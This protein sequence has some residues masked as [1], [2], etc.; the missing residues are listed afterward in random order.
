MNPFT[1]SRRGFLGGVLGGAAT[2]AVPLPRAAARRG[3]RDLMSTDRAWERFLADQDLR[4][5]RLPRAWYE[6]PFLGDGFLGSMVYQEPGRNALRFTIH[7]S[8]VQDHRPTFGNEW[9]VARLPVGN[10]ALEPAGE[11]TDVDLRLDLW[12]AELRG[13]LTTSRGRIRLRA[14]IE[15]GRSLL[16]VAIRTTAGENDARLVYRASKAVSPRIIREDPPKAMQPNPDPHTRVEGGV[17]LTVQPLAAGGQTVTAHAEQRERGERIFYLTVAHSHP[18]PTAEAKALGTVRS[19]PRLAV[20]EREHRAWWHRFYRKSFISVPDGLLQSFYWIQLYKLASAARADA[21]IMAT[22][23]PW[24][25]PTPWPSVWNNLNSQLEYWPVY[26]S[27]HL[28]LDPIPRSLKAYQRI[29]VDALRPEFRADSMGLRRST[30]AQFDDAGFV[31]A[32]GYPS[33]DPEIGNLPWLLHNAWLTYRHSMDER[34]LREVVFPILRRAMNYYLHFLKPGDDGRLHLPPTFSPEYGTAPDCNYDLALIRWSCRTLLDAAGRLGVADPLAARWQE[35]LD[36][37]VDPP[38]DGNGFMVGTGVPFAKSHRHYSHMLAVYPLYLVNWDR[39]Q[40]R[41]LIDRS[42]RHWIGFEGA[43]RGYSFTGAS[44][45]SAS[46]GRGDDAL[47]YLRE[48]V[49]RFAQ[50]NTHYYEAGPVIETPLSG[51]QSLHDMLCQSWGGVIRVFPAV[52]AAWR[53]V[54]LHNFL[55]EGAFQVSAVRERGVTRFVRV[56]SLAG[57]TCRLRHGLPGRPA[58]RGTRGRPPAWRDL[59]GGV[60]EIDLARG[61]EAIVHVRG[62]DPDL[63]IA[64]VRITTKAPPWG[65]PPLPPAGQAVPVELAGHFDNDGITSE[66]FMGDGDFDGTGATYPAAA[67]PQTGRVTADG[68]EFLFVNGIEGSANNVTAAGQTIPV[69]AGRYA[70]LHVLGASDNGNTDTTVTAVY[71]DGSSAAVPLRLTDWKSNPAYGESA[72]VRAPQFHTRT[73]AKD[74]AVTIFHQ[75]ADLDPARE[76]TA[77]RLP[78]LTRPRPHLFSLTLEK[79]S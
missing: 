45:I 19:A 3:L 25:E 61:Q 62:T 73:G 59:G 63:V 58:V 27:N 23:G 32:P 28:E 64:P 34:I 9:G 36:T 15:S 46:M 75:K 12:N 24:L 42:L 13:T 41:D 65:L 18:E 30:D 70:R 6:G 60:I 20:L 26:G 38:V 11:I 37:L 35:V 2:G 33:P 29:L 4:W 47:K 48:F 39:P 79:P 14:F 22:T 74:I 16:A 43:L 52:P 51:A 8:Q 1:P 78:N 68:V 76:L 17:T 57:E 71:A 21:P 49:A 69:P 5:A 10:L 7:H 54:T 40:D 53:D 67:L 31:G 55:T 77:L 50:P 44:S 66:F 72:A 56:L